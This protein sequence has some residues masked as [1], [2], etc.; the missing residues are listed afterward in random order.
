LSYYKS[1]RPGPA[2]L[3]KR[4]KE[5]CRFSYCGED[6][7]QI[8][9][10]VCTQVGYPA[11]AWCSTSRGA[12]AYGQCVHRSLQWTLQGNS[13]PGGSKDGAPNHIVELGPSTRIAL[14]RLESLVFVVPELAVLRGHSLA[15]FSDR[16]PQPIPD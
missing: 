10:K 2:V 15:R 13:K 6:V 7:V 1:R 14:F 12:A 4:I 16:L 8:L 9:E 11:G 5:I 3:E